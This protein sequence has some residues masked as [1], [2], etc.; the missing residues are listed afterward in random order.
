MM[1]GSEIITYNPPFMLDFENLFEESPD[2]ALEALSDDT[3]E[4]ANTSDVPSQIN[5][6]VI[7]KKEPL[8]FPSTTKK[9]Q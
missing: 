1:S 4:L 3:T 9:H 8:T 7:I 5:T 2:D 6:P